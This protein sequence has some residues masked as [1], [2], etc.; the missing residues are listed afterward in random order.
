[1][2]LFV[3]GEQYSKKGPL[4]TVLKIA[5]TKLMRKAT[6]LAKKAVILVYMNV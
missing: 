6:I 3:I 4:V 1:M 2:L 5:R